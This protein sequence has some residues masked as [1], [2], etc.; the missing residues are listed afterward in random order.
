MEQV[1]EVCGYHFTVVKPSPSVLV[2]TENKPES[3][4][5]A[6]E[7]AKELGYQKTDN[8]VRHF[9]SKGLDVFTLDRSNGLEELIPLLNE[10]LHSVKNTEW[11]EPSTSYQSLLLFPASALEEYCLRYAKTHKAKVIAD[12]LLLVLRG[13]YKVQPI[14]I[15]DDLDAIDELMM[16][17]FPTY[18]ESIEVSKEITGWFAGWYFTRGFKS[19]YLRSWNRRERK[20]NWLMNQSLGFYFSFHLR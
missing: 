6:K 15:K 16:K 9:R 3:Y 2:F 5:I 8:L 18:S 4:F 7:I 13:N 12:Q 10:Y 17:T 1:F 14:I 20:Y 11:T 19:R